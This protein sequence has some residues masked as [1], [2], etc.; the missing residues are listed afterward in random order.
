MA[1]SLPWPQHA[2]RT[3][4]LLAGRGRREVAAVV[5]TFSLAYQFYEYTRG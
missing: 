4:D 3:I 1:D 2:L 5:E